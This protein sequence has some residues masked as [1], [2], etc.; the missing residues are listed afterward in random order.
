MGIDIQRLPNYSINYR[1]LGDA[2]LLAQ[3]FLALLIYLSILIDIPPLWISWI[4]AL[5]PSLL[6]IYLNKRVFSRTPF[7]VPFLI[8]TAGMLLGFVISSERV[9]ATSAINTYLASL[10]FY[11]SLTSNRHAKRSYWITFAAFI[12]MV[13]L[14]L[15]LIVF[16]GSQGKQVIFNVWI[17]SLA[18]KIHFMN[19]MGIHSNVLGVIFAIA[20]PVLSAMAVFSQK[21]CVKIAT[22]IVAV[23][24]GVLLILSAS[25][26]GWIAAAIGLFV[27][28]IARSL[29]TLIGALLSL[30]IVVGIT[31][32]LWY[33]TSW[34]GSVLPYQNLLA[35]MDFWRATVTVLR[36]HPISGLGLGAW[37]S[38][39]QTSISP[40]GPHSTYLQLYSDCGI[41]GPIALIAA[42]IVGII[43]FQ[44]IYNSRKDNSNYGLGIG[45][46]A[47][48]VTAA[49]L[50][51]IDNIF[52]V[53]VPIDRNN[54]C[55]TVPLIVIILASL[56]I[57]SQQLLKSADAHEV[58]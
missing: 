1:K 28:L 15:S 54:I 10:L 22:G 58:K 31:S 14:S 19:A 56:V 50:A 9:L 52:V 33:E 21:L 36:E 35:R 41:L 3:P 51:F 24:C 25:G 7:D 40:G 53:L 23:S 43:L 29:R 11:Y 8:L 48:C 5:L 26:G 46:I 57:A 20:L 45:L 4:V 39:A 18:A 2:L 16:S 37:W 47:A 27:V 32:P 13:F 49:A 12:L 34:I 6:G 44:K 38:T 17:Y 30:G 55:F 42:M